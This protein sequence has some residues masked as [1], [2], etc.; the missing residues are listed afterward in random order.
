LEE[1][2]DLCPPPP[3]VDHYKPLRA[4]YSRPEPRIYPA[5]NHNSR[6]QGQFRVGFVAIFL[7]MGSLRPIQLLCAVW[8]ACCS[9][10]TAWRPP[11]L[12]AVIS[13]VIS[14]RLRAAAAAAAAAEQPLP[15]APDDMRIALDP[16]GSATSRS[17]L[18]LVD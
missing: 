17:G 18:A 8:G 7:G 3:P 5:L 11:D 4:R 12:M 1:L 15:A 13:H 2:R 10:G 14:L 16:N 6:Q 9:S